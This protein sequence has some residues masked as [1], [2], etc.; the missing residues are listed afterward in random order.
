MDLINDLR[1][2]KIITDRE[3]TRITSFLNKAPRQ[4]PLLPFEALYYFFLNRD[5]E[6]INTNVGIVIVPDESVLVSSDKQNSNESIAFLEILLRYKLISNDVHHKLD[7]RLKHCILSEF[8]ILHLANELIKLKASF[9]IEK[10]LE[11]ADTLTQKYSYGLVSGLLNPDELEKLQTDIKEGKLQVY[12]DFFKYTRYCS[13]IDLLHYPEGY[14]ELLADLTEIVNGLIYTVFKIKEVTFSVGEFSG[15]PIHHS[16]KWTININTGEQVHTYDHTDFHIPENRRSYNQILVQNILKSINILLADFNC[17]YRFTSLISK[18]TGLLFPEHYQKLFIC[19]IDR[20][21]QQ[22]FQFYRMDDLFLYNTPVP[23]FQLP[24]SYKHIAYAMHHFKESGIFSS[25]SETEL[26]TRITGI[27]QK[28][29]YL[30]TDI[31]AFFPEIVITVITEPSPDK[32]PYRDLLESL[33][34]ISNGIL[35]FSNIEDGF[36]NYDPETYF[37]EHDFKVSFVTDN[38]QYTF[39]CNYLEMGSNNPVIYGIMEII[40]QR[41]FNYQLIR[42]PTSR[43]YH[44]LYL[45]AQKNAISYLESAKVL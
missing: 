42:L 10:Q 18:L 30:A 39:T 32:K 20:E 14:K 5:S 28:T 35:N 36:P 23:N 43:I 9:T 33:N 15:V 2:A 37:A 16:K 22:L 45:F 1:N 38:K 19:R 4:H 6:E 40:S 11:F 27:Y 17:S 26:N 7:E 13:I 31:L 24:I 12:F 25:L 21:N 3:A 41:Y 29:Y 8:H 44:D 34:R